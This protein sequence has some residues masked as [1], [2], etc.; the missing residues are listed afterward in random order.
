M[1]AA[2][3]LPLALPRSFSHS[4]VPAAVHVDGW[5][6]AQHYYN[7]SNNRGLGIVKMTTIK[8][9]IRMHDN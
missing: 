3:M 4:G 6:V 9:S 1:V 8:L 5:L 2:T 7:M